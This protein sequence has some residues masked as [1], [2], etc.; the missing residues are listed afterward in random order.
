MTGPP[1]MINPFPGLR[2]FGPDEGHLFFGREEIV[3]QLLMR[4]RENRFLGVIGSSGSG[5]SSLVRAGLIPSLHG[6]YMIAAGSSWRIA[7][8]RPGSDP[9]GNLAAAL[10][11]DDVL[12]LTSG[13]EET[14]PVLTEVT[15]RRSNLG[16]VECVSLARLPQEEN[17]LIVIDQ[18]EELF[19][20]KQSGSGTE[21]R[22]EAVAFVKRLLAAVA[23]QEVPIY[24]VLTMRS[25]F[26]GDCNEY[27]GLSE[28][29]ND[30]NF[31]V[32][33]MTRQQLRS[34]ISGPVLVAGAEIAPRLLVRLLNDVGDDL[35]RL[36]ILQHALMRTW[37][38]WQEDSEQDEPL[39]IRHYE[40]VG[41]IE[42]ALSTHANEAYD[43]LES[44]RS[45]HVAAAVFKA[46]TDTNSDNRGI[47][48]P[49]TVEQLCEIAEAD[50]T[51]V[52][53]VIEAFRRA[54]RSF[55]M[56][57]ASVSLTANTIIDISHESLM[58]VWDRLNDWVRQEN[59]SARI[60]IRLAR[61]AMRYESGRT[62]L[63]RD[64]DL[65]IALNW[66]ASNRP[67]EAWAVRYHPAFGQA[68]T[69]LDKCRE[70]RDRLAAER[71]AAHRK[72]LQTAW[73]VSLALL[74]FAVY[75]FLQ[76]QR[77]EEEQYRAEQNF[78]L[79]VRAV[80]EMLADVAVEG[81][82]ADIP[83]T[84]ELRQQLLEK[85]RMFL[86]TLQEDEAA[87][88]DLRLETAIAQLRLGRIY[89]LKGQR[90]R[91][92]AAHRESISQ[93]RSLNED[94]PGSSVYR[95]RLGE[96]YNWLGEQ[97]RRY[98]SA[99]AEAA[100]DSALSIQHELVDQYADDLE[101]RYELG[102]TY[103]NRGILVS[104]Q[105]D[106]VDEAEASF[107]E[108]IAIFED[109]R[110]R[111]SNPLDS[112]RLARTKN[113][114]A[115]LLRQNSRPDEAIT[116]YNEAI[117][118]MR[119]LVGIDAEKREYRET[120]ARLYNNIGN[121]Y[122]MR[123]EF[124]NA[125]QAN[126]ESRRLFEEL[127]TPVYDLRN[128]IANSHNTR[129][130]IL[131]SLGRNDE[132][133]IAYTSAL[134][135]FDQL[136][137]DF[138]DFDMSPELQQRYGNTLANIAILKQREEQF[139]EAIDFVTQAIE[140]YAAA[141]GSP[142][143]SAEYALSLSNGYWLLADIQLKAGDHGAAASAVEALA[144]SATA[145]D[146]IIRAAALFSRATDLALRDDSLPEAE[147]NVVAEAYRVRT[148]NLIEAAIA[149][150]YAAET[151][152]ANDRFSHL[153]DRVDYRRVVSGEGEIQAQ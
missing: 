153:H 17:L 43:G 6:G 127:A 126:T 79:A 30:G 5:K 95:M 62:G 102:R 61:A 48:R 70:E 107:Q 23:Q 3:D 66:L 145:G 2:P 120:L 119:E 21:R 9:I 31:I 137:Q 77:A 37:D 134:Q 109:L 55:L 99:G 143:S 85:A 15:L 51:E 34:A 114:L 29:I 103:N 146:M 142:A 111:R 78:Q 106:R 52:L 69:F 68:I 135:Q 128:E 57:P 112:L 8:M 133:L 151:V 56:P 49:T 104:N 10:N 136:E 108:A 129:G 113:N 47:R 22:D 20:F 72:K 121:L 116:V 4:L 74:I 13:I 65:E 84:E 25:D 117:D 42:H 140:Y 32:P 39:D 90:Q 24:I 149:S 76:Q 60:Y 125:L 59:E 98:D 115:I 40:A 100:Y 130:R 91:A 75:A 80:D 144:D 45:R 110:T 73:G 54:D 81:T 41:T 139:A 50:E 138:T 38:Q 82:L 16:L 97:L 1:E 122:L 147:R 19:R 33:R 36:P 67:T 89:Q 118:L 152:I 124:E 141:A 123:S 105:A 96:A 71:R 7:I 92:E 148:V 27:P 150:G 46:L 64:P 131:T 35:D 14:S 86:E 93:L 63:W 44:D 58:R 101:H 132:A 11:N 28:A 53:A 94:F 12:G 88:P 26:I 18:F 83:Q 87:D